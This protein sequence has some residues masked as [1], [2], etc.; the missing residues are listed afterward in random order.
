[1]YTKS[2]QVDILIMYGQCGKNAAEAERMYRQEYSDRLNH[3]SRQYIIHLIT[4]MRQEPNDPP[5]RFIINEETE[6][7]VIAS[8]IQ[9]PTISSREIAQEL[10]IGKES[11]RKILKKH[12]YKSFKYQLHQHLYETDYNRRLEYCNWF[13][14]NNDDNNNLANR[15]LYSDESRF[16]NN[17]LFNRQNTRYWSTT[18]EHR[19]KEGNFQ[20]KFGVNAWVGVVGTK[21]VG[22]IFFQGHLTGERYLEFLQNEI[23][24]SLDELPL[25]IN[26]DQLYFQQDGAPPHN[27]IAVR[28]Y[29]EERFESNVISTH[30]P[31]RWPPRSP[32]LTPIDFFVWSHIK[33]IVYATPSRTLQDLENRIQAAFASITPQMLRNVVRQNVFRVR[34]CREV[35]GQ[36][37]ENF[38]NG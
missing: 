12:G 4:K 28:N 33:E 14:A 31:I 9:N 8:V 5:Q 1:M 13:L 34:K 32:D 19:M 27:A 10:N 17:G 21:I 35:H 38:I 16:T 11:A 24:D 3:P 26:N 20:E 18:N 7:N 22:P 37:F 36:H 23:E 6:V 30:G 2:E 29:L 25:A 15:I